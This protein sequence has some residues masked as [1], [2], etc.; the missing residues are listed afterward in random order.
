MP[1]YIM[2]VL[3]QYSPLGK[4]PETTCVGCNGTIFDPLWQENEALESRKSERT[5]V[6]VMCLPIRYDLPHFGKATFPARMY[7]I[8]FVV[9]F[10]DGWML[11]RDGSPLAKW[12]IGVI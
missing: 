1:Q 11:H 5:T 2:L 10:G 6:V 9:N 4:L 7:T 3:R 12:G 8:D